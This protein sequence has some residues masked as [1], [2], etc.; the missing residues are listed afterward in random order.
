MTL[1]LIALKPHRIIDSTLGPAA[2]STDW[3]SLKR[4]GQMVEVRIEDEGPGILEDKLEDIF[5][6]FYIERL[7]SR[8]MKSSA[9]TQ[10]LGLSISKQIVEAHRGLLWARNHKDRSCK[11]PGAAFMVRLP[12]HDGG[13][14]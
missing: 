7:S 14:T 1:N 2:A 8:R 12:A 10:G 11:V 5:Q 3:L 9:P 4:D 13:E 6:R